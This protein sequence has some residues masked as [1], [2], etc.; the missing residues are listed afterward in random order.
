M[1]NKYGFKY[2]IEHKKDEIE[3]YWYILCKIKDYP[4]DWD[5]Y[6]F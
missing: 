3:K 6:F 4:T 1:I 2:V 5:D